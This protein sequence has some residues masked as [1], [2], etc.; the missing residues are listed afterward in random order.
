MSKTDEMFK[1]L[2]Y[3]KVEDSK[4]NI[5]YRKTGDGNYLEIDFWKDDNT[6]SKNNYRDMGYITM[7][8]L[9]AI[10]E[11]VKELRLEQL[12]NT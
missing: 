3:I 10:N 5:E 9:Q 11:K 6:V 2:G 1:K 12:N 4:S 7:Q 8:E